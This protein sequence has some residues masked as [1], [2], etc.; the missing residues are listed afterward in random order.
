MPG[1][2][3]GGSEGGQEF[4]MVRYADD[5]VVLRRSPREAAEAL[6]VVRDW[7]EK[8]GLT[9]GLAS[10]PSAWTSNSAGAD[11]HEVRGL[12]VRLGEQDFFRPV[13]GDGHA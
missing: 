7:T 1:E 8:A 3:G 6:T 10:P 13:L 4:E 12:G 5:F 2:A 9:F 11:Q